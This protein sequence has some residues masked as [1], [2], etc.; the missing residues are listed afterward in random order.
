MLLIAAADRRTR[1]RFDRRIRDLDDK[2]SEV[3]QIGVNE[4][5]DATIL[6]LSSQPARPTLRSRRSDQRFVVMGAEG[7]RT[8]VVE[9]V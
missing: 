1:G 7:R 9:E 8:H 4:L 6:P 3:R 2:K 5:R